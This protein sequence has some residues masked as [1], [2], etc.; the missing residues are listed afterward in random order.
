MV[1][2]SDGGASERVG[3]DEMLGVGRL[4]CGSKSSDVSL[5][6]ITGLVFQTDHGLLLIHHFCPKRPEFR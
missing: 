5:T 2:F 4:D 3:E 1:V 6:L